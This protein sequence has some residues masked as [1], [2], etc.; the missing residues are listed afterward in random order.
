VKPATGGPGAAPP[1]V[2]HGCGHG[3]RHAAGTGAGTRNAGTSP[4]A[5]GIIFSIS[6]KDRSEF[7]AALADTR[8]C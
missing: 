5:T 4:P 8:A 3:Q 7:N 1:G 2:R 6:A